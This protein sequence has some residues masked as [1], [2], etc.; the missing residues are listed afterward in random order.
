[1]G[2]LGDKESLMRASDF[3]H[4]HRAKV[5]ALAVKVDFLLQNSLMLRHLQR[6]KFF[7]SQALRSRTC[8]NM[9]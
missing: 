2:R 8:C 1:M 3:V 5:F 9:S 4:A 6:R 7:S